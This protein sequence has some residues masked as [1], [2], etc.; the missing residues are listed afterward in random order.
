MVFT[1]SIYFLRRNLYLSIFSENEKDI[2]IRRRKRFNI[3]KEKIKRIY[4]YQMSV[5]PQ[6]KEIICNFCL[7]FRFFLFHGERLSWMWR[8]QDVYRE[9]KRAAQKSQTV[10]AEQ[11]SDQLAETRSTQFQVRL[12]WQKKGE[13][14]LFDLN[15]IGFFLPRKWKLANP[16]QIRLTNWITFYCFLSFMRK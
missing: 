3:G 16:F 1:Y 9:H 5:Q 8:W 2:L 13:Y 12:I 10:P 14:I 15:L 4:P 7:L 6:R 11:K